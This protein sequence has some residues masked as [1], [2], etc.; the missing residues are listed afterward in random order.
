MTARRGEI[1]LVDLAATAKATAQ[2]LLALEHAGRA[3]RIPP[4]PDVRAASWALL[5]WSMDLAAAAR[6]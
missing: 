2:L 3:V 1:N 5:Y 4:P 6:A